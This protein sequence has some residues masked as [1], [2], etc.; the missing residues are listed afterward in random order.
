MGFCCGFFFLCEIQKFPNPREHQNRGLISQS[1]WPQKDKR[2]SPSSSNCLIWHGCLSAPQTHTP[3][4][5]TILDEPVPY[6]RLH[7]SL[8]GPLDSTPGASTAPP[9]KV[10]SNN[11]ARAPAS[12]LAISP[13]FIHSPHS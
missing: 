4:I 2:Y 5:R 6:P 9:R 8:R 7:P 12:A 13:L 10:Q 1:N 3:A 11:D